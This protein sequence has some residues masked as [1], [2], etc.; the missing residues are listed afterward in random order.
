M[1]TIDDE[2]PDAG[3]VRPSLSWS[4][5]LV[6]LDC[7][8]GSELASRLSDSSSGNH[9]AIAAGIGDDTLENLL[10]VSEIEVSQVR[11]RAD[12]N[13]FIRF[14]WRIYENDP[15]WV[16]PL[17]IERKSFLDRER[18]P[19]YEHGD[20]TLFLARQNGQVVGRIM[21]SDDPNYNAAHKSNVG[22]FGQFECIDDRV[23][24]AALFDAAD[25]WLRAK[26]RE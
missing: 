11:S 18:H 9:V 19:F 3:F 21:A 20:A 16:P 13:S 12:R 6:L 14:P 2:Y 22:C 1:G 7:S 8:Y 24:A 4:A 17:I 26:G 15:A 10:F 25:G 5:Y 23:V